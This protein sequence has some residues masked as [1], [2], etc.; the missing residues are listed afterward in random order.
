[1]ALLC[2]QLFKQKSWKSP[3]IFFF[4]LLPHSSSPSLIKYLSN[5]PLLPAHR[6]HPVLCHCNLLPYPLQLYPPAMSLNTS[7]YPNPCTAAK[8][9][10]MKH[11]S[12]HVP[13]KRLST[14]LLLFFR[15]NLKC[16]PMTTRSC[17]VLLLA[18]N[19]T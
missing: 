14:I 9:M 13:F 4:S 17:M 10:C 3:F 11:E 19:S 12:D 2:I 16:F 5:H 8:V 1:M 7:F 15:I 18:H 6:H